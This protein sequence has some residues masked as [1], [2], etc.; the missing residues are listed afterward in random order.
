M[1]FGYIN[2]QVN[3]FISISTYFPVMNFI[4]SSDYGCSKTTKFICNV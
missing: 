4:R 1:E 3:T 2:I